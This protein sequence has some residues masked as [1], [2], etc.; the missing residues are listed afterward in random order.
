MV[1]KMLYATC[2]T[3]AL[4]YAFTLSDLHFEKVIES[5]R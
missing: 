4:P 1:K 2:G 3:I 5:N